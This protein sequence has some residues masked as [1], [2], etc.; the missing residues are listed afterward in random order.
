MKK[1]LGF[2]WGAAVL[3]VLAVPP[4]MLGINAQAPSGTQFQI[5]IDSNAHQ[6]Y[7]LYYPVTYMFQIP[8]GVSGLTAQY[9][10]NTG[11]TW[12]TLGSR[13]AS[14]FFNAINAARLA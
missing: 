1:Y 12:V 5:T 2:L 14:D 7:G 11:G 10:F 8:S 13:T 4:V 9:R 6:T 3:I